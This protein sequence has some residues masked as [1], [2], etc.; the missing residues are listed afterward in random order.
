MPSKL[1]LIT[2]QEGD[3]EA[4]PPEIW[5]RPPAGGGA[6]P[7]GVVAPPIHLP[8]YP[9][10]PIE[11]PPGETLPPEVWPK[12]PEGGGEPPPPLVPTH[13]IEIPAPPPTA[14]QLPA[15]PSGPPPIAVHPIF[16]PKGY[17]IFWV[18]GYGFAIGKIGGGVDRPTPHAGARPGGAR[19]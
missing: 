16:P 13:P 11:L 14:V 17:V 15:P 19:R 8:V 5:P 3:H 7:P 10:H 2:W 4:P 1:A 6:P 12:P 18:P 9:E